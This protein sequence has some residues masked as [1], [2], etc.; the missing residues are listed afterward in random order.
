MEAGF[1]MRRNLG[2]IALLL[3]W[4]AL[5]ALGFLNPLYAPPLHEVLLTLMGLFW[6]G[7]VWPHLQATFTA[8]LLGL[9][10]ILL[11][12]IVGLLAAFNP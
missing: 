3:L 7:E 8:A 12:G 11:W 9:A 1:A 5:S 10:G 6:E 2:L 4:E